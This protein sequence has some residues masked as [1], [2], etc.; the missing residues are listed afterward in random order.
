MRTTCFRFATVPGVV[1]LAIVGAVSLATP[2]VAGAGSG[3]VC[4]FE[5][6]E[7]AS[8]GWWLT[9]PTHGQGG[10]RAGTISCTG[11]IEGR[12]VGA[13]QGTISYQYV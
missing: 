1:V 3:A 11:M 10:S 8:P 12:R 7:V 5:T 6:H 4:T 2:A 9:T 13:G